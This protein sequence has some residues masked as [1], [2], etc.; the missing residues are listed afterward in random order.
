MADAL[1]VVDCQYDFIDGALACENAENAVNNIIEYINNNNLKVCYSADG[2]SPNHCSFAVNHHGGTWPVH[3]VAGTHGAEIH[4]DFYNKILKPENR[5]DEHKNIYFKGCNDD[6]EQYSAFDAKNQRGEILHNS[7]DLERDNIIICGIA[8]EFCVRETVTA[9]L[10]AGAK[11]IK[12]LKNALA[13]VNR[14]QH[15]KNLDDLA[16]RGVEII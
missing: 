2:H 12:I 14:E 11:N 4:K 1:I 7:L 8:S 13:W 9:L 6:Q 5:P 15:D 3:C 10:D 16:R